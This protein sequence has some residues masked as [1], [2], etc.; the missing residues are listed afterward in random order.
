M[1]VSTALGH[2]CT[3]VNVELIAADTD[4]LDMLICFWKSLMGEII[5]K[6]EA[7]KMHKAI[8]CDI[9]NIKDC[10]ND[11]RKYLTL[12]HVSSGCDKTST[13]YGHVKLPIL[14]FLEKFKSVTAE[15]VFLQKDRIPETICE[16]EIGIIII[17]YCGKDPY[18][19]TNLRYLK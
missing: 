6:Y 15:T 8:E 12:V 7:T 10:N 11:V 19:L 18:S 5:M 1:V 3:V 4:L 14:K 13:I 9:S 2:A 16:T 17:L